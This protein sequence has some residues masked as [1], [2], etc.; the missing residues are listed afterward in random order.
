MNNAE[1]AVEP[2]S[3]T[4]HGSAAARAPGGA[5][6]GWAIVA[7]CLY[8]LIGGVLLLVLVE[9]GLRLFWPQLPEMSVVDRVSRK[10]VTWAVED[11][12]L[13]HRL[14]P[15][16]D[17]L[18][19]APEF[20]ARYL[21]DENGFRSGGQPARPAAAAADASR[22]LILGDSF[23]FGYGSEWSDAWATRMERAFNASGRPVVVINTGTPGYDTRS[24]LFMLERTIREFRPSVVL[25]NFLTNDLFTNLPAV[26]SEASQRAVVERVQ[27]IGN[28]KQ[29]ELHS[30]VL[31]KR[32][33]MSVDRLYAQLY[34]GTQR[35]EYFTLPMSP[36]L[37]SQLSTTRDLLER[38]NQVA[39]S[40]GAQLVV[41]SVPQLFQVLHVANGYDFPG[42]DSRWIDRELG[43]HAR[44]N[45][46]VWL[47]ALD[48]LA[49]AYRRGDT[50]IYYRFDGHLTPRGNEV[51]AQFLEQNAA[52]LVRPGAHAA[53][54]AGRPPAE[55]VDPTATEKL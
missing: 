9:G 40:N 5:P 10:P 25:L 29:S 1:A 7:L 45:G 16:T 31:A 55:A 35:R 43:R 28:A 33:L 22:T 52:L 14:R 12:V 34:L 36:H 30:V 21:T 39:R 18:E 20:T 54:D 17:A 37:Q 3:A 38:M 51:L 44:E 46:Y 4:E 23:A 27:Q 26:R 8:S 47:P 48:F 15:N 50:G 24:E 6:G 2:T 53:L 42:V 41:L 49:D 11:E 32:A 19:R 13:G